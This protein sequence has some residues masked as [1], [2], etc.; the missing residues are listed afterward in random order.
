MSRYILPLACLLGLLGVALGAFGAHWLQG[1]VEQWGLTPE[2]QTRR[3]ENW[4]TAVRYAV[5]H[6]IALLVVGLASA[7][8]QSATAAGPRFGPAARQQDD[9][10]DRRT[11]SREPHR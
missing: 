10:G 3:L 7:L 1:A 5:F 6:A 11:G 2:L 9:Q 4:E 8:P